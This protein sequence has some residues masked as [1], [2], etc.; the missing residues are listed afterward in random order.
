MR[1]GDFEGAWR[2]S[3]SRRHPITDAEWQRPRHLQRIWN[4]SDVR[5]RRVLVR[6]YHGLGDTVQF[7][8][9]LPQLRALASEV[10]L[11]A[12]PAL[13]PLLASCAGIDR[14][15]PLH[16]GTPESVWDVDV[17]SMELPYLLRITLDTLPA[18]VPYLTIP[19]GGVGRTVDQTVAIA[20]RA[21]SWD[22]RRSIP[23][24]L[25]AA[26]FRDLVHAPDVLL[27]ELT[28]AEAACLPPP[29]SENTIVDVARRIAAADLVVTV[30]TVFAHL[31]GALARP[32]WVLLADRADWRWMDGRDDS[33]WYPTARLFR[34]REP[35][36]WAEVAGRVRKALAAHGFARL[37]Y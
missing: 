17:E 25:A 12:Q 30:D 21:G 4:G 3:D 20:W 34:Q 27:P 22:G 29:A 32:A 2:V 11:W 16:D 15:M 9:F 19:C 35:D 37:R 5:G 28:P 1:R 10:T 23:A 36:N 26:M 33:P 7:V 24:N 31:A 6:C 14:L 18:S 13:L 8:R